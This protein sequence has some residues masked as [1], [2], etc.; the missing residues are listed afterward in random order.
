M[1]QEHSAKTSRTSARTQRTTPPDL[2]APVDDKTARASIDAQRPPA[3]RV[4]DADGFVEAPRE[5]SVLNEP[6]TRARVELAAKSV[7]RIHQG[8]VTL[9]TGFLV[10]YDVVMTNRHVAESLSTNI[11]GT[12]KIRAGWEPAIDFIGDSVPKIA[13]SLAKGEHGKLY[14]T[15]ETRCFRIGSVLYADPELDIALLR[16]E[17][18]VNP[19]RGESVQP[20]VPVT[21]LKPPAPLTL[22]S[23]GVPAGRRPVYVVGFPN[24][25]DTADFSE[26]KN[27]FHNTFDVKRL[28]PGHLTRVVMHHADRIEIGHDC[29]T[30]RG[31]SG[32]PI[33]DLETNEVLGIH[34]RG[35]RE[36]EGQLAFNQGIGLWVLPNRT[37]N[38][39]TRALQIEMPR[40]FAGA[41]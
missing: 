26:L 41:V 18:T 4:F 1:C 20:L 14:H 2:F 3:L 9:G 8:S 16:I 34:V 35:S 29:S 5:W 31:N 21:G 12:L 19:K 23:T 22:A 30:L 27:V 17:F 37:R 25:D 13:S 6:S 39:L 24:H 40:T 33:I 28:Q 38:I 10:A 7:G 15:G 11:D 36:G 32:S